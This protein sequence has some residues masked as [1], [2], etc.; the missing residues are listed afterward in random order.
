MLRT[1][2]VDHSRSGPTGRGSLA[3]QPVESSPARACDRGGNARA[4]RRGTRRRF[5]R[6]PASTH[7]AEEYSSSHHEYGNTACRDAA[8][9]LRRRLTGAAPRRPKPADRRRAAH[10]RDGGPLPSGRFTVRPG[11]SRR[12]AP[13]RASTVSAHRLRARLPARAE[14]VH[15]IATGV[16]AR[17]LCGRRPRI[18]AHERRRASCGQIGPDK[19]AARHALRDLAAARPSG[20]TSARPD[21][22]HSHCAWRALRRGRQRAR[23]CLQQV[24]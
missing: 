1:A 6:R 17:R 21:R 5:V 15:A 9:P 4:A 22:W 12:P 11:S 19:P 7:V 24:P 16:G 8:R 2:V 10:A 14:H 20:G 18:P 13:T 23:S 3:P